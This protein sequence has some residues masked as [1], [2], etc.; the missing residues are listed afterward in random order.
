[1]TFVN[2]GTLG[3]APGRRD[4]LVAH[5]TRRSDA[6][7]Q[8]GCLVYEVGVDDEQPNTVF[9]V[10][11][12]TDE[13]AHRASLSLPEVRASIADARRLLSGEVGGFRFTAA[14]SPLHD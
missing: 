11:L 6:L 4:E 7:S 3:S 13:E 12:W 9:V 8:A 10:E 2:A 1:V 5:L 14:G